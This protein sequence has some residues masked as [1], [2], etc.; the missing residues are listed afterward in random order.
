M[1][2]LLAAMAFALLSAEMASAQFQ[3]NF[4]VDDALATTALG[5][6][7]VGPMND[8]VGRVKNLFGNALDGSAA[9]LPVPLLWTPPDSPNAIADASG[10]IAFYS[11]SVVRNRLESIAETG[12]EPV[13][14]LLVYQSLPPQSVPFRWDAGDAVARQATQCGLTFAQAQQLQFNPAP[15]GAGEL[16]IRVR[17]PGQTLPSGNVLRWQFWRGPLRAGHQRFDAVMVHEVLHLLGYVSATETLAAPGWLSV[18]DTYRFAD[19]TFPIGAGSFLSQDRELRPTVDTS[20]STRLNASVGSGQFFMSR[21]TRAGGDG[22]QGS[23][24]RAANRLT[25][26]E[27]IGVM[28]PSIEGSPDQ[29]IAS[30]S[31]ADLVVLDLLGWVIEP[32]AVSLQ[33]A[34]T[35]PLTPGPL[36]PQ[37]DARL[38]TR[39]PTFTWLDTT[40]NSQFYAI[41]IFRGPDPDTSPDVDPLT[42]DR[43][44]GSSFTVPDSHALAPGVYTYDLIGC[45]NEIGYYSGGYR[46]FVILCP[47]DFDGDTL[48]GVSDIFAFLS[49]W[50][51]GCSAASDPPCSPSADFNQDGLVDVTDIFAFLSQ[52]FSG[53]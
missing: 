5:P 51:A 15:P 17:P 7:R 52:W 30:A 47:A 12:N 38:R 27:P 28:D 4:Q 32:S 16:R 13:G 44:F 26:P 18:M 40:T 22:N 48:V 45:P 43:I 1:C 29:R 53:C 42:F 50:F 19:S 11:W 2:G 37:A 33:I 3:V 31:R 9:V 46:T 36:E 20:L 8:A 14:E 49:A 24:F 6:E 39:T 34:A 10:P 41:T 25:P 35:P 23:H 21:G